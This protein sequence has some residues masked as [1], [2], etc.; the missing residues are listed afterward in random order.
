MSSFEFII[1]GPPVSQIARQREGLHAWKDLVRTEAE[2]LWPQG[3][4]PSI[5]SLRITITYYYEDSP[6]DTN[7]IVKPITDALV[8]LVLN[9]NSQ[10]DELTLSR[11]DLHASF[12]I[13]DFTPVLAEGF[14]RDREFL[15][16][17]IDGLP[18]LGERLKETEP[19]AI[20][21]SSLE[22]EQMHPEFIQPETAP[23]QDFET[24]P[25]QDTPEGTS[26]S[27]AYPSTQDAL[28][29]D[30]QPESPEPEDVQQQTQPENPQTPSIENASE[31][32]TPGLEPSDIEN[33]G[34]V[35]QID[36]D[37]SLEEEAPTDLSD[38]EPAQREIDEGEMLEES[39][40]D[41][42]QSTESEVDGATIETQEN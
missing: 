38:Q 9:D 25:T 36:I 37:K 22:P 19:E 18:P 42:E 24:Q 28:V 39:P 29:E 14:G 15:H 26:F 7:G 40:V 30:E 31:P 11:Q 20:Q 1:D 12:R 6:V 10:I 34:S 23:I 2:R 8:G 27:Q 5:A 21:E 35:N 4:P 32:E 33:S 41:F 3:G 16:V 13:P 17:K